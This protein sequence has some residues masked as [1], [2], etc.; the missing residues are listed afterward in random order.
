[1]S[2][3]APINLDEFPDELRPILGFA[4]DSMGFTAQ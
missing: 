4:N 3:V 1:M 2:R